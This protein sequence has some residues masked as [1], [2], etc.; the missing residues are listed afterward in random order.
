MLPDIDEIAESME[1]V[2]G[3][4]LAIS[5]RCAGTF[6]AM[7]GLAMLGESPEGVGFNTGSET[8]RDVSFVS[9]TGRLNL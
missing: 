6:D 4:P 8:L 3:G 1:D 7:A 9:N 5:A 2:R